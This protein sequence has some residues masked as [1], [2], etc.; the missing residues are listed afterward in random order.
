MYTYTFKNE[1]LLWCVVAIL[2]VI[3]WAEKINE[4]GLEMEIERIGASASDLGDI[5]SC[6][7][8]ALYLTCLNMAV[9]PQNQVF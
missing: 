3:F 5:S 9:Q 4:I 7:R 6:Q 2:I 8:W 1:I